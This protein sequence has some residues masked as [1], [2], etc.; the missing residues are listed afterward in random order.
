MGWFG[1][2]VGSSLGGLGGAILG[3]PGQ[4]AQIGHDIGNDFLPFRTGGIMLPGM[5]KD[6][7]KLLTGGSVK[8]KKKKYQK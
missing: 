8:K 4:G 1:S 6:Y 7:K 5:R 2:L 3:K